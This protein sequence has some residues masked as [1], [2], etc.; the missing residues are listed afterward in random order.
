MQKR[1]IDSKIIT[2]AKENKVN[3]WLLVA[4]SNNKNYILDNIL[5]ETE[6]NMWAYKKIEELLNEIYLLC[7]KIDSEFI[8]IIFPDST[9]VNK[10]HFDF[11]KKCKFNIDERT[12]SSNKPQRLL[13]SFCG[14]RNIPCI[15]LL[16][17]FKAEKNKEF[18]RAN[19][20]Y[21]NKEGCEFSKNIVLDFII[22]NSKL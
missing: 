18:Y 7:K 14:D 10:S 11:C 16:S 20:A 1:G 17:Y 4:S 19:D 2:L 6:E 21:L 13:K 5:M 12:L 15:D 3:P 8:V 22:K 9:Q